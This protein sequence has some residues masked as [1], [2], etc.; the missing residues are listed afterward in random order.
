MTSDKTASGQNKDRFHFTRSYED[1][2]KSQQAGLVAGFG[3]N[4][5]FVQSTEPR[6]VIIS[7]TEDN[8][9]ASSNGVARG[10][11]LLKIN[12]IDVV[13]TSSRAEID[14]INETLFSPELGKTSRS[15]SKR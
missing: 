4:W 14:F 9:P 6:E 11:K 8:S 13:N 2:M 3:F 10:D 7:Y 1:Y 5:K 15:H 12:D